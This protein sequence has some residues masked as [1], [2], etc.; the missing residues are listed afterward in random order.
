MKTVI[1]RNDTR[2]HADHGWLDTHHTF[3]F[4]NYHNPQRVNF[5]ALRVLNDDIVAP[6][7]GF[8]AHPHDNM[9]II[10][11]PIS[12]DLEH[13]DSEGNGSIIRKNDV[14]IMSA[15]TGIFHSERNPSRDTRVNF[16]QIWIFPKLKDIA[17]RYGQRTYLPEKRKNALQL[18]V[19]PE[20]NS[21]ETLYIN[22]DAWISLGSMDPGKEL[23]YRLHGANGVYVFVISGKVQINGETLNSR[24]GAGFSEVA[25]LKIHSQEEAEILLIEVPLR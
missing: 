22:Q 6:S 2:G 9:E 5:G 16:L 11:I 13:K 25:E 10:S 15:G 4:A 23:E 1:H 21:Q 8:G 3:S 12:G 18:V 17:P 19:A 24:D 14:Q 20:E 7:M